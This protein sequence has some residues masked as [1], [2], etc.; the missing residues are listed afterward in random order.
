MFQ[1]NSEEKGQA[2]PIRSLCAR[3]RRRVERT[4][5]QTSLKLARAGLIS[6]VPTRNLVRAKPLRLSSPIEGYSTLPLLKTQ[7]ALPRYRIARGS[8]AVR[9]IKRRR[10]TGLVGC[11]IEKSIRSQIKAHPGPG[12]PRCPRRRCVRRLRRL[13]Q[14]AALRVRSNDFKELEIVVLRHEL[15]ILRRQ[16]KRPVLTAV[17]RLFLAS[18]L[19]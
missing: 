3:R 15:A 6:P 8:H 13:L 7:S 4:R 2:V 14:L 16:R 11:G 1:A 18:T 19:R 5:P 9:S 17:D 12:I 10:E